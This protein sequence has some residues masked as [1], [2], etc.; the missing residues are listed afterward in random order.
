MNSMRVVVLSDA[1]FA[2]TPGL[3]S[4]LRYTIL[5]ADKKRNGNIV[6]YGSSWN[7]RITR[8]V[9][10]AEVNPMIYAVHVRMI[11]RGDSNELLNR[12]IVMVAFVE[13]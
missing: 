10:T 1:S 13:S 8:S 11:V 7:H 9:M 12:S 5:M 2:T 3:K 6:H 4:Q